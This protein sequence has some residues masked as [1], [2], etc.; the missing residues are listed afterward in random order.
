[1]KRK[2]HNGP[3][4]SNTLGVVEFQ[5]TD[6]F[7]IISMDRKPNVCEFFILGPYMARLVRSRVARQRMVGSLITSTLS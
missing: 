7:L 5:L 6:V 3:R 1:M 2:I 4:S